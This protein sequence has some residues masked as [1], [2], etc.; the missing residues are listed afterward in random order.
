MKIYTEKEVALL[1]DRAF[2]IGLSWFGYSLNPPSE[3]STAERINQF[4]EFYLNK[5]G[6]DLIDLFKDSE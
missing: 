5:Y 1:I 6:K 3:E 4:K 2:D